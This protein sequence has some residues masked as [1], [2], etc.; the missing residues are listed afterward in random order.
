M[1]QQEKQ[2]IENSK[3]K[4]PT[5]KLVLIHSLYEETRWETLEI[6]SS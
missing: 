6:R 3:L 5:T 4:Q 1:Y 2:D